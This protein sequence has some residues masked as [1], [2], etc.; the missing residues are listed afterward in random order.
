[1]RGRGRRGHRGGRGVGSRSPEARFVED[2]PPVG[3]LTHRREVRLQNALLGRRRRRASLRRAGLGAERLT[4]GRD[5]LRDPGLGA[6]LLAVELLAQL[7]QRALLG[8]ARARLLDRCA[9]RV[10][11]DAKL[12]GRLVCRVALAQGKREALR[13]RRVAR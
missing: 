13:E 3:R 7:E 4:H 2:T 8:V 5:R 9:R 6:Q 11:L 1:M 12:L 10:H